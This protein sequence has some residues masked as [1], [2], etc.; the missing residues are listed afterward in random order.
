M[1][2]LS[3]PSQA[4]SLSVSVLLPLL[5]GCAVTLQTTP[6]NNASGIANPVTVSVTTN[7]T[8]ANSAGTGAAASIPASLDAGTAS[9]SSVTLVCNSAGNTCTAAQTLP[10]GAHT[11]SV[12]AVLSQPAFY[13]IPTGTPTQTCSMPGG[14][15]GTVNECAKMTATSTF[16]VNCSKGTISVTT[17]FPINVAHGQ[18]VQLTASG[19]C[20]P[21]SWAVSGS[22]PPGI[23]ISPTGLVSGTYSGTCPAEWTFDSSVKVTDAA[24]GSG[25]S[26][27]SFNVC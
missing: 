4:F 10:T 3:A 15:F 12:T 26:P 19:G 7:T 8:I 17:Q 6:P 25:S 22:L 5:A 14:F 1:R 24:G 20:P 27:L 11:L 9:A 16:L 18:T 2:P 23:S 13:S 21:Y